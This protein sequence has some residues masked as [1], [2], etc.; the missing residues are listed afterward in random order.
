M[1]NLRTIQEGYVNQMLDENLKSV[2]MDIKNSNALYIAWITPYGVFFWWN[3]KEI[4]FGEVDNI[5]LLSTK[6]ITKR[7][8]LFF[9]L[10]KLRVLVEIRFCGRVIVLCVMDSV[11]T[12]SNWISIS[13]KNPK[14]N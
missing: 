12:R 8:S 10:A 3:Y 7:F 14:L 11:C 4:N 13:I 6:V 5:K 2:F 9:L 1:C